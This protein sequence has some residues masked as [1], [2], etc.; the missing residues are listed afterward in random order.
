MSLVPGETSPGNFTAMRTFFFIYCLPESRTQVCTQTDNT[1]SGEK[2]SLQITNTSRAKLHTRAQ[3]HQNAET[4]RNSHTRVLVLQ[5][6][7]TCVSDAR[8]HT[9]QTHTHKTPHA[10]PTVRT[11]SSLCKHKLQH[12]VN[13]RSLKASEQERIASKRTVQK[14]CPKFF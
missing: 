14:K 2:I 12:H 7:R 9:T 13:V 6:K 4:N 11:I 3:V 1:Q 10:P 5:G 8:T